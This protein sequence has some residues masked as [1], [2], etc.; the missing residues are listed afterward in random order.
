MSGEEGQ[1]LAKSAEPEGKWASPV[2][3][4][5]MRASARKAGANK[6]SSSP[7]KAN[8]GVAGQSLSK[9][10][11]GGWGV[12]RLQAPDLSEGQQE[13]D[14]FLPSLENMGQGVHPGG[15]VVFC[16]R[17]PAKTGGWD[18]SF[19]SPEKTC[20]GPAAPWPRLPPRRLLT[21]SSRPW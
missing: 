1:Q 5:A 6:V 10:N 17:T 7:F 2:T 9:E 3:W 14:K 19:P 12:R 18:S 15:N 8:L 20:T 16:K 11:V 21:P 4:Q 13:D